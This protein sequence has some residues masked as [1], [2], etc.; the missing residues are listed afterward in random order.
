MILFLLS[1]I[2]ICISSYLATSVLAEKN[3]TNK[4]RQIIGFIY[5]LLV[6]FAQIILS[7]E[8]LSIFNLI[9]PCSFIFLNLLFLVASLFVWIKNSKPLY[10]PNIV[11]ELVKIKNALLK[12]KSL[13]LLSAAFVFFIIITVIMC[14]FVPVNSFDAF[15]YHLARVP[16]WISNGN[17]NH[18]D[19]AD[20]RMNVMPINSE[21]LYTWV[22]LFLKKD[23]FLSGFSFCGYLLA[24]VALYNFLGELGYSTRKKLWVIF[25]FSSIASIL[26]E[27]SSTETDVIIGGLVLASLYLWFVY[28]KTE[29]KMILYF[30]ALSYAIA[31]GTKTPAV[32]AIPACGVFMLATSYVCKKNEFYKPLLKFIGFF[33]IN[34]IVFSSYNYVLNFIS[35]SNPLGSASSISLHSFYGGFKAF[36]GNMIRY[37]F[38]MF[39]FSGFN[40]ADFFGPHIISLQNK[41]LAFLNIPQK[42]GVLISS[43]N[44]VNKS[45]IDPV[46][47]P[48]LLGFLVFMPCLIFS[49]FRFFTVK[50]NQKLKFDK[51][52]FILGLF[53]LLFVINLIVMSF[54]LG[55][56]IYS[57]RF[58]TTFIVLSSPVLVLSYIKSNKNIFK[59]MIMFFAISYMVVISSHL[60]SRPFFKLLY[61]YNHEKSLDSFRERVS[62]SE[63][64][65]FSNNMP[66][67]VLTRELAK[68]PTPKKILMF[69]GVNFRAYH[70]KMMEKDGWT[71]DFKLLEDYKTIDL[72]KYD[73][74]VTNHVIQD[75]EQINHPERISEY[76]L[77]NNDILFTKNHISNCFYID[78]HNKLITKGHNR[79]PATAICYIPKNDMRKKGFIQKSR[80]MVYSQ[81]QTP[82]R[83]KD[84]WVYEKF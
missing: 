73:Y 20:S 63:N 52:K 30:S 35:Y 34:F 42:Y 84:I 33:I 72:S 44:Q 51:K 7:M 46:I 76:V 47:G 68:S 25:M 60:S 66:V 82:E 28:L 56:M 36:V 48:G 16:F 67:C 45:L 50:F 70:M 13:I 39:D 12:D 8:I 31:V 2:F 21:L 71:V 78:R 58:I 5:F 41:I 64:F 17:L 53:A 80:F 22:L 1:L 27:A 77:F 59:W 4:P 40:Y 18:F 74:I 57:V 10:R 19:I 79:I 75:S 83:Y 37:I 6:A 3:S 65:E 26:A 15:S 69:A 32:M 9:K 49:V 62:C 14:I 43:N 23:W 24:V 54:T 81:D 11:P 29:N 61:I 38:L 55:F